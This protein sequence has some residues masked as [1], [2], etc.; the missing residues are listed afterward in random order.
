MLIIAHQGQEKQGLASP[1]QRQSE[2]SF[3]NGAREQNDFLL[4]KE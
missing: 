2:P 1:P 4:G 3:C